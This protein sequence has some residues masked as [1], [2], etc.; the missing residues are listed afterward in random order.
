MT[1][2]IVDSKG[3]VV[4]SINGAVPPAGRAG[5]AGR[6]GE[7]G[8]AGGAGQARGAG[9]AG[10][11]GQAGGAGGRGDT[12]GGAEGEAAPNEADEEGGGR[13]R[14]QTA[15]M[16]PGVQRFTWDLQSQ[17]VVNFPGMVLWGA[18]PNG[19]PVLPGPLQALRTVDGPA[20]RAPSALRKNP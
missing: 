10:G 16:S 1:L 19:Q 12:R 3:Q 14:P 15:N 6:A 2:D 5:G 7:A 4:R 9:Q 8:Q 17:P 20:L 11:G 18:T 13:G